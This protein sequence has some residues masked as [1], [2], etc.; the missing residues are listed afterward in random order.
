MT[1]QVP[2]GIRVMC[3]HRLVVVAAIRSKAACRKP[4][5]EACE[6]AILVR[7]RAARRKPSQDA[8]DPGHGQRDRPLLKDTA[9]RPVVA[10]YGQI[11]DRLSSTLS[12][13]CGSRCQAAGVHRRVGRFGPPGWT[14][15]TKLLGSTLEAGVDMRGPLSVFSIAGSAGTMSGPTTFLERAP[16]L[17]PPPSAHV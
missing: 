9:L 3:R 12:R 8:G 2:T 1:R 6:E 7:P 5:R 14:C 15:Q 17:P 4:P 11:A 16:R 10:A 13:N